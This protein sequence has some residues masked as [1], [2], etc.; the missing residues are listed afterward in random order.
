[1]E[2]SKE[3]TAQDVEWRLGGELLEELLK[4]S[5]P[6]DRRLA[7][8]AA[9]FDVDVHQPHRVAVFETGNDDVDVRAMRVASARVLADQPRAVLVTAL[10]PGRVVL[11]V[12][13][14]MDG[15]VESLLRA[16]SVAGGGCAVG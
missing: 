10:P 11:A 12:P 8:R 14:S 4:R 2:L 13:R 5:E 9:R 6:M 7:A 3:R 16:L 1:M 15:S